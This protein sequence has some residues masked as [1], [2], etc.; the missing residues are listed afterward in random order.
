MAVVP[1]LVDELSRALGAAYAELTVVH[2]GEHAYAFGLAVV[3]EDGWIVGAVLATEEGT[4]ARA[5]QYAGL[6]SG[7]P[8]AVAV[9]IR[10]WDA[11][12]PCDETRAS[13]TRANALLAEHAA[14][15]DVTPREETYLAALLRVRQELPTDLLVGVFGVDP[16]RKSRSVPRLNGESS[17]SRFFAELEAGERAYAAL[18]R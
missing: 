16:E 18:Q 14:T 11:D 4:R 9:A 5:A 1:D 17:V 12:W 2:A 8:A 13:F 10:W 15:R 3:S 6:L 7:E